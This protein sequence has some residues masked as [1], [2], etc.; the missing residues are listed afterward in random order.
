VGI[1]VRV[2]VNSNN[3]PIRISALSRRERGSRARTDM[4]WDFIRGPTVLT[5]ASS[6]EAW[7]PMLV[8]EDVNRVCSC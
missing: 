7:P 1:G 3:E 2:A 8:R 6:G 5:R 4:P